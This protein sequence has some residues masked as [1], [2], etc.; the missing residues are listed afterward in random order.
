MK[1][2]THAVGA[3]ALTGL[4]VS[5]AFAAEPAKGPLSAGKPA[6]VKQA[7]LEGPGLIWLGVAAIVAVTIAVVVSND[8]DGVTTPSTGTAP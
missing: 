8:D 5:S 2:M 4:L 6:G 3:L 7:A 1:S